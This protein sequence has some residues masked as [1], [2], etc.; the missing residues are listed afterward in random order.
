MKTIK[1]FIRSKHFKSLVCLA[2]AITLMACTLLPAAA[3]DEDGLAEVSGSA[4]AV[5]LGGGVDYR[6]GDAD[7]DGSIS[8]L[9]V[10]RIQR[11]L[12]EY[13]DAELGFKGEK[14]SDINENGYIDIVDAAYIQRYLADYSAPDIIGAVVPARTMTFSSGYAQPFV[15]VKD[16][17]GYSY[18]NSDSDVIRFV[19][20]VETDYDTDRDGK[21]DLVKTWVQLPRPAAEGDYQAPVLFEASPYACSTNNSKYYPISDNTFDDTMLSSTPAKRVPQGLTS[22]KRI[23]DAFTYDD[24]KDYEYYYYNDNNYYL[25]RGFALVGSSGLGTKGSEGLVLTGTSLEADSFKDIVEWLH[26]D[27][28]AYSNLTDNIEVK[29]DWSNGKVA[30]TGVSYLGTLAYEVAATGVEGLET[31]IPVA[32]IGSWYDYINAQ[33]AP[34]GGS[35]DYTAWLSGICS[36]RFFGDEYST[37]PVDDTSYNTYLSWRNYVKA[38]EKSLKGAY[39]DYWLSRDF[40]YSDKIKATGLIVHGLGDENVKPKQFKL[41]MEAFERNGVTAKAVLHQGGHVIAGYYDSA[42]KMGSYENFLW[43]ANRWLSYYLVGFDSGVENLPKY[44]VQS[45]IDGE[46]YNYD[47]WDSGRS[48]SL[49]I[50]G[51]NGSNETMIYNWTTTDSYG[52]KLTDGA[53]RWTMYIDDDL[54]VKGVP[55][56]HLRLKSDS[57]NYDKIAI[58]ANLIDTSDLSFG[59]IH[60]NSLSHKSVWSSNLFASTNSRKF[61][62]FTYW[63]T[64]GTECC[65][66]SGQVSLF[67]PDAGWEPLSATAPATPVKANEWH[68]YVIYLDPS[69]YTVQY[70]HKLA[71]ELDVEFDSFSSGESNNVIT[72]DTSSCYVV[73]P[74]DTASATPYFK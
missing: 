73:I 12:A 43:L 44:M 38:A 55:E 53:P 28:K 51:S 42:L 64:Y 3:A 23:A 36:S 13:S 56:V 29:A 72:L 62:V 8:I 17:S 22:T 52:N 6:M 25:A 68:D 47:S 32:A 39:G 57:I 15:D 49:D 33:G 16:A 34:F 66:A 10:T 11:H 2:L 40:Y 46:F 26:G 48:V 7:R 54:T 20:Y 24:I 58:K 1:S 31:V 21:P 59:I 69:V 37:Y 14:L 50:T 30:M 65:F 70:G 41:M 27:R 67:T 45:N 74:T 63:P 4:D 60:G 9:D 5:S 35:F 19:V 61:G 71:I 18:S